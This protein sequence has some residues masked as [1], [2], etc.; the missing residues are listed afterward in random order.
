VVVAAA[1][2][3]A[4]TGNPPEYPAAFPEVIAVAACD[5]AGAHTYYSEYGSYVDL[6]APGGLP[7]TNASGILSTLPDAI[8][9]TLCG[10]LAGTS[11]ATPMVAGAAAMLLAQDPSRTP[12]EVEN[13]LTTTAEKVG[14]DAYSGGWNQYLGWGRINVYRA[15]TRATTFTPRDWRASFL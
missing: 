13:L 10:Y 4:Q 5:I 3:D 15:L 12:E 7:D 8:G 2:N 1:G 9:N 14:P 6:A 11:M